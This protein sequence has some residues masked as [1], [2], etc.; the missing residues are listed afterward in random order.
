MPIKFGLGFDNYYFILDIVK[1]N[2]KIKTK[3]L[4]PFL[5]ILLI[6]SGA[7]SWHL[8]CKLGLTIFKRR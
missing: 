1:Q 8:F 4:A 3:F 5:K 6:V 7:E 2:K